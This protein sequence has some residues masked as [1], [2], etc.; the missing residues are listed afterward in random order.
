[1]TTYRVIC[2]MAFIAVVGLCEVLK[3]R[4]DSKPRVET[5]TLHPGQ[6]TQVWPG[7]Y[8][9]PTGKVTETLQ[10]IHEPNGGLHGISE[11][12]VQYKSVPN[13]KAR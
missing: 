9:M 3:Q 4:H 1:M 13:D 10:V 5:I 7:L 6:F 11:T 8:A 2:L 12:D